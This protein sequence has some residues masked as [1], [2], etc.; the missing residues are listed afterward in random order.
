MVPTFFVQ[1]LFYRALFFKTLR[2]IIDT[3][4]LC[5]VGYTVGSSESP[6][7]RFGVM[8]CVLLILKV[9]ADKLAFNSEA[10]FAGK[11]RFNLQS[12]YLDKYPYIDFVDKQKFHQ[13]ISLEYLV[14]KSY[15]ATIWAIARLEVFSNGIYLL[16]IVFVY[17]IGFAVFFGLGED[18]Y[19]IGLLMQY[20]PAA[21]ACLLITYFFESR[22]HFI[23][24]LLAFM[25]FISSKSEALMIE[26]IVSFDTDMHLEFEEYL[27]NIQLL[28]SNPNLP[29]RLEEVKA[30]A[31]KNYQARKCQAL[32][33]SRIR[34]GLEL[35][36]LLIPLIVTIPLKSIYSP[37]F[38]FITTFAL[39]RL[40]FS[41]S[42]LFQGL[43]VLKYT[44]TA[45]DEFKEFYSLATENFSSHKVSSSSKSIVCEKVCFSYPNGVCVINDFSHSF[46]PSC[47]YVI[48]GASGVGK[49]TLLSLLAKDIIPMS[50]TIAYPES[51]I[52]YQSQTSSAVSKTFRE[53]ITYPGYLSLSDSKYYDLLEKYQLPKVF[54]PEM[55]IR[56]STP[57]NISGGQEKRL[58][59]ARAEF[60]SFDIVMLDEPTAGLDAYTSMAI[61]RSILALRD[62]GKI[63]ICVSH[64][65][66][67]IDSADCLIRL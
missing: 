13:A 4:F 6:Y 33:V 53:N 10:L 64:E 55:S 28:K 66:L 12:L 22:C 47:L 63:I 46:D 18:Y 21:L 37:A 7:V 2:L 60:N 35:L 51:S 59:L 52:W 27:N 49:S 65:K 56:R 57:R 9:T 54:N 5:F 3:L 19:M 62:E 36:I 8:L 39:L 29:R 11:C 30:A 38:A 20:L 34:S 45:V 1:K 42:A 16:L 43:K 61:C 48:A 26:N 40:L 25:G 17:A 50:G 41:A 15:T 58:L 14:N 23:G 32:S 67:L 44:K 24:R 31:R